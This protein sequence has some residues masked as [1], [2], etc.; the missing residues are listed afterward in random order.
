MPAAEGDAAELTEQ[1][2]SKCA[3]VLYGLGSTISDVAEAGDSAWALQELGQLGVW[4][5]LEQLVEATGA[6]CCARMLVQV[7][8]LHSR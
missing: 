6:P 5:L 4:R 8:R 3:E 7:S 1:W 2:H